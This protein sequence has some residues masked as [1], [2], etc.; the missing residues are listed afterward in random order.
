MSQCIF[1]RL[2]DEK[3]TDCVDQSF[4]VC[5]V[6]PKARSPP[7]RNGPFSS[8]AAMQVSA[9]RMIGEVKYGLEAGV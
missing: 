1:S 9:T 4:V 7:C 3:R 5:I 2:L 6:G 8:G